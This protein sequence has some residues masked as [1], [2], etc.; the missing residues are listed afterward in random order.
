MHT[1]PFWDQAGNLS[2]TLDQQSLQISHAT[3][4]QIIA[5]LAYIFH[6]NA[7]LL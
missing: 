6:G 7:H 5:V 4:M 3:L 2:P 1:T